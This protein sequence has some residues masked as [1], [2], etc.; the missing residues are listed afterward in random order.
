MF[1]YCKLVVPN[2]WLDYSKSMGM[3]LKNSEPH[4]ILFFLQVIKKPRKNQN[5]GE[6]TAL[7]LLQLF[8]LLII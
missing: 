4:S 2:N 6:F 7:R 5:R 1:D 8:F 3:K